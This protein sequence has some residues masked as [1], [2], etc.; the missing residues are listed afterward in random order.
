VTVFCVASKF[1]DAIAN[2][3][4]DSMYSV[5]GAHFANG[6]LHVLI[7]GPL[8]DVQ[9]FADFPSRFAARNPLQDLN[10]A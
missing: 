2:G 3:Q 4:S 10:L 6:A 7:D 8:G 5:G 1:D 9:N